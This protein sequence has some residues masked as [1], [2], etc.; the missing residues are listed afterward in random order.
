MPPLVGAAE[1]RAG[2]VAVREARIHAEAQSLNAVIVGS[3]CASRRAL[4][5]RGSAWGGRRVAPTPL[6]PGQRPGPSLSTNSPQDCLCPG[7][8][9]RS[10]R[11]T[12]CVRVAHPLRQ[13]RRSG[14]E[15]AL[16]A[17]PGSA[18][19][20][21]PHVAPAGSAWREGGVS[22]P[23]ESRV[24]E[25]VTTWPAPVT[26]SWRPCHARTTGA[27]S[28]GRTRRRAVR[29]GELGTFGAWR[30]RRLSAGG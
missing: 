17:R 18:L 26:L 11:E 25:P 29:D 4:P 28:R 13:S 30:S 2:R 1:E 12:R 21:V 20:A 3:L 19:L 8:G 24:A 5:A 16:R 23:A 14:H 27:R 22:S 9:P 15:A 10:R 7:V 6:R